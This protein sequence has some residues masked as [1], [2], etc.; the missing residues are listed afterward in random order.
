MKK[1]QIKQRLFK[2]VIELG[3]IREEKQEEGY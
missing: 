2:S 3:V 1:Q